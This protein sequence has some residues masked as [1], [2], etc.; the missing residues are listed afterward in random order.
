MPVE[1]RPE[2]DLAPVSSASAMDTATHV[3]LK[4]PFAR[5]VHP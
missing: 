2:R 4:Q 3:I 5:Y 1:P